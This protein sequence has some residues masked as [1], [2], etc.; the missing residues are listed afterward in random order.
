MELT[1]ALEADTG[2]TCVVG[3]GGKKSTLYELAGRLERA[4]VTA[5]VRIPI[6]DRQVADVRVTE[7]PLAVLESTDDADL[8]WPLGLVPAQERDDRYRG[9][10]PATVD[11]IASADGVEHV[12]VKAD[13]ARTR[14]LKAPNEREP[15]LPETA[16][17]V[18]AIASVDAVGQPLEDDVVHRPEHVADVTG[19]AIGEPIEPADVAAVLTSPEGG[20]KDVPDGATYVPLLNMVDDDDALETA[21][22]IA[23]HIRE[24]SAAT[25]G[26][27][28]R[29]VLTS[30]I[31]DEPLVDVY[32]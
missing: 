30:M 31:A 5:T 8:E 24:E 15:Q 4:V 14:L 10:D 16:E 1:R 21:R 9:Y 25:H 20:L 2:L 23:T 13:G 27:V 22:E 32:Q 11:R 19:R 3:A 12:L 6:F 17:T 29:V 28:S 7:D 18:I 26:R